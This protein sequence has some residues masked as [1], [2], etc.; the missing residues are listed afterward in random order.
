V[1]ISAAAIALLLILL[2]AS[3]FFCK[4]K[5][6]FLGRNLKVGMVAILLIS[7][8]CGAL[9][10]KYR[11]EPRAHSCGN[12]LNG[13]VTLSIVPKILTEDDKR[14]G[15]F[16]G[17]GT[18]EKIIGR[19]KS[20][21][22]DDLIGER[23]FFSVENASEIPV[24]GQKFTV[25]GNL[26]FV[27]AGSR[28]WFWKHLKSSHVDW[29][30]S[31]CSLV[32]CDEKANFLRVFVEKLSSEMS[33]LFSIG[34]QNRE[35]EVGILSAMLTGS[36]RKIDPPLKRI[37]NNLGIAH[38]FAVSGIH[39][40]IIAATI[41]F[42]LKIICLRKKIRTLPTFLIL[43]VY[44]N[45]IGCSPSSMRALTMVVFYYLATLLGRKPNVLSALANSAWVHVLHDPFVVFSISF[46]LSYSVVAGIILIGS[47]VRNFLA[48]R[49]LNLHNLK[50]EC[51]PLRDRFAFRVKKALI[52]S[53][54]ISFAAYLISLPMS[55]EYFGVV[56]LLTIPVNM[57]LVPI[58]TC[59]IVA[60]AVALLFGLC[61]WW[62]ICAIG[63]RIACLFTHVFRVLS[64][65][66]YCDALCFSNVTIPHISGG[67]LTMVILVGAY[68]AIA[69]GKNCRKIAA[70]A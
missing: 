58:A 6:Y 35:I 68:V 12:K 38:L 37:F 43:A 61:K 20:R 32:S 42:L 64:M 65:S 60:G 34:V 10:Y 27:K 57:F 47:P 41:D 14:S 31:N 30:I 36:K 21:R 66:L 25:H 8:L 55:V 63:N 23:I 54:S 28:W 16:Y 24:R 46:L 22:M 69:H 33:H 13:K 56:S 17:Y 51:Y 1:K 45:A 29:H 26:K 53:F 39:V 44:V 40:G 67:M 19:D 49:F 48:R 4:Q 15:V 18:M 2:S 50:F 9:Y 52:A 70:V 11:C 5:E 62:A 3:Y 59:A 7:M